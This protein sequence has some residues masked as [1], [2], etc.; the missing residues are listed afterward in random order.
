MIPVARAA[1]SLM[2]QS[3]KA[4]WKSKDRI[5]T[6]RQL[7]DGKGDKKSCGVYETNILWSLGFYEHCG[8]NKMAQWWAVLVDLGEDKVFVFSITSTP[9]V[10]HLW[11]WMVPCS[12]LEPLP[13]ITQWEAGSVDQRQSLSH[14]IIFPIHNGPGVRLLPLLIHL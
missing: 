5:L 14:F 2:D 6:E 8:A 7:Y 10:Q 13:R 11:P 12:G 1:Y 9:G 3:S 4:I